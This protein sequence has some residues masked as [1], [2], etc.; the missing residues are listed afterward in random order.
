MARK[1][2][3]Y[4]VGVDLGGTKILA[5]VIDQ[6]GKIIGRNK[7]R[8]LPTERNAEPHPGIVTERL[9]RTIQEAVSRRWC[10]AGCY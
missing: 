3:Q 4:V 7:K 6:S 10:E 5:A 2:P 1:T 8:T 9:V